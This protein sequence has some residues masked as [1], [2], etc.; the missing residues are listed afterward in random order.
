MEFIEIPAALNLDPIEW[1][2]LV[3]FL[4]FHEEPR[5]RLSHLCV[6]EER[7]VDPVIERLQARGILRSRPVDGRSLWSVAPPQ[8]WLPPPHRT[9]DP[10]RFEVERSLL[11]RILANRGRPAITVISTREI[12]RRDLLDPRVLRFSTTLFPCVDL[13]LGTRCNLNC[14]Y[15][16][17]GHENR[18]SRPAAE[19][20]A[21]LKFARDQNLE[22]VSFTGGEP[23]LHPDLL[24]L[25]S[26][27]RAMGFRRITLVTNGVTL[28]YPGCLDRLVQAGVNAVGI[29]FDTP[30]RETAEAMWQSPV[31]DRVVRAFDEVARFPELLLQSI[32]V[33]TAM[34]LAQL[35]DLARFFAD[36]SRRIDNLFVP[37]LD[38]VMPEENAWLNHRA[39]V[40]TLGDAVPFVRE[41]LEIAHAAGLPLTFRGFPFCLL[42]G[43][44]RFS[45]DR[46]MTIFQLVRTDEG[47]VQDRIALDLRRT[48]A[49]GCSE[50][51][52]SRECTG[53]TR[54]YANL[55]GLS[56]LE[57]VLPQEPPMDQP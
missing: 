18:Y 4:Q 12:R 23:T 54:A 30:H 32:A 19:V 35:P 33:V 26:A 6:C 45:F 14:V 2:V 55:Y 27:A 42:R 36:L 50:C 16:L 7:Q 3:A 52:Y 22:K 39:V 31:F 37:T 29:S 46:Y 56:E 38:F 20:V 53:V 41:A 11:L 28:P 49:P 47:V 43:Y 51:M 1:S 15:C 24:K 13:R 9:R 25:V 44:E 8:E 21:D 48:R 57:P 5:E 17:L 40:P 10:E 34:N